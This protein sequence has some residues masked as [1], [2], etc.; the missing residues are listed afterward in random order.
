ML[1]AG[2]QLAQAQQQKDDRPS[3]RGAF[4]RSLV[5]P[6]WGHYY[7]DNDNWNRGKFHMAGEAVLILSYIGLDARANN[8]ESNYR[9]MAQSK[10]GAN[11]SGKSRQYEI[12]I[13][14]YDNLAE[15]NDAQLRLSNW[16]QLY[17]DNAEFQWSWESRDFRDQYQDT[18]EQ[19]DRN[20]SQLPTLAALMVT[21][22]LISAISAFI[23]ARDIM[24]NPPEASFSYLN[25]FGQPGVTA[26]LRF[27]F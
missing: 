1:L 27:D 14:N 11:L 13:G 10:A 19:V 24:D 22:R 20:R 16:T 26:H 4:L 3:P 8:L 17:P 12:A 18:R 9:T 2:P 23:K 25:E 6:G 21:N 5:L 7:A 15:Y